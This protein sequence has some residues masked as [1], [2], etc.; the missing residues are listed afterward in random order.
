[1][2]APKQIYII[3]KCIEDYRETNSGACILGAAFAQ[4]IHAKT[5]GRE[6]FIFLEANGVN[7][8]FSI[9]KPEITT[10]CFNPVEYFNS[11]LESEIKISACRTCLSCSTLYC[12]IHDTEKK[13]E[14]LIYPNIEIGSFTNLQFYLD[15]PC[16]IF[17]F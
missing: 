2:E 3:T 16:N 8:A 15:E 10:N 6:V 7:W 14:K 17:T 12:A 13:I 11:C 5:I 4:A 9:Y 1:M